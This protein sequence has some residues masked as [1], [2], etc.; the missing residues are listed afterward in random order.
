M[1]SEQIKKITLGVI[2]NHAR[3]EKGNLPNTKIIKALKQFAKNDYEN[4]QLSQD[5]PDDMKKDLLWFHQQLKTDGGKGLTLE[6]ITKASHLYNKKAN[7]IRF[8]YACLLSYK[9]WCKNFFTA[10]LNL[11]VVYTKFPKEVSTIKAKEAF[12]LTLFEDDDSQE[13]ELLKSL[14]SSLI[15]CESVILLYED[16][17]KR[18]DREL[19]LL[20]RLA[21][22][23][24]IEQKSYLNN[25]RK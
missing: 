1:D 14:Q 18:T 21:E 20:N 6:S 15:L 11:A 24:I 12:I 19:T 3:L 2:E 23:R 5:I 7:Y 16:D 13:I 10:K 17:S 8:K 4:F 22:S 25:N 9:S